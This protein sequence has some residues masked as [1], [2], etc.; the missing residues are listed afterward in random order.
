MTV[1]LVLTSKQEYEQ[2]QQRLQEEPRN[3]DLYLVFAD[4]LEENNRDPLEVLAYR[5]VAWQH[6]D[7]A[8]DTLLG[9]PKD[10]LAQARRKTGAPLS[11]F[12]YYSATIEEAKV[13]LHWAQ[14]HPKEMASAA[15]HIILQDYWQKHASLG[16][17][18]ALLSFQ[19]TRE[20]L[21]ELVRRGRRARGLF[22]IQVY[23]TKRKAIAQA[24]AYLQA[25]YQR[26]QDRRC[27]E[28]ARQGPAPNTYH[29]LW[30]NRVQAR[31]VNLAEQYHRNVQ[32]LYRSKY[33]CVLYGRGGQELIDNNRYSKSWH[34]QH[35]PSRCL[36]AGAYV[37]DNNKPTL[38]IIENFR[39]TEVTRLLYSN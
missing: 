38:V 21:W 32:P 11:S 31:A 1:E 6:K 7:W 5:W 29:Q 30:Q 17:V 9:Y 12:E 20:C 2:W 33:A 37:N 3:Y 26:Q 27:A 28:Q 25:R 19:P 15:R 13:F 35:G 34:V 4:W 23:C 14:T 16:E 36:C 39:G 24:K 18:Q 10:T 22:S 8:A